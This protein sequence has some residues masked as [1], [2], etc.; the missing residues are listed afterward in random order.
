MSFRTW[1]EGHMN[2]RCDEDGVPYLVQDAWCGLS[3]VNGVLFNGKFFDVKKHTT[4]TETIAGW[5]LD[6]EKVEREVLKKYFQNTHEHNHTN[7]KE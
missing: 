2:I 3:R 5:V 1:K 6:I 7:E 4:M